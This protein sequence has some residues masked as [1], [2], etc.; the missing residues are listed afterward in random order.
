MINLL[1]LPEQFR[2]AFLLLVEYQKK[3]LHI[4]ING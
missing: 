3:W 4:K 1:R 2:Q